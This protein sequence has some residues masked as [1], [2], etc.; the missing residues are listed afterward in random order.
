MP[1]CVRLRRLRAAT[2]VVAAAVWAAG[3]AGAAAQSLQERL[4]LCGT[5]HGADGN[6]RMEKTPS[7]AGQPELFLT[8]QMILMRDKLRKSEIMAPFVQGMKDDEIIALSAHYAKQKPE[9]SGEPVDKAAVARGAEIAGKLHC[10]SCHLPSYAGREQIPRLAHQRLD[11]LIDSLIGYRE[12]RRSGIDT[13]MNAVMYEVPDADIQA[14]ANY[15]A[16]IR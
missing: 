13:S 10:A 4:Q 15:L 14:L 5:C 8:N 11:Y 16:T 12:G 2:L 3:T 9:P 6:S 7:L 1:G